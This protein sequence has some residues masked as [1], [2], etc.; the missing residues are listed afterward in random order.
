MVLI[1]VF[2][3]NFFSNNLIGVTLPKKK[4]KPSVNN[5]GITTGY[6]SKNRREVFGLQGEIC[7]KLTIKTQQQ[8]QWRRSGVFIVNFEHI[9]LKT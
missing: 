6:K 7:A 4:W 1:L 3:V 5:D 8:R 2:L 9:D